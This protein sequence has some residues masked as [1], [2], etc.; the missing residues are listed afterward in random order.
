MDVIPKIS[1]VETAKV[2][3]GEFVFLLD[4]GSPPPFRSDPRTNNCHQAT[5]HAACFGFC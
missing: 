5:R 2:N 3:V 1:R 4:P